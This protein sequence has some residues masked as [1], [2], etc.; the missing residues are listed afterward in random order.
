MADKN[1]A[2]QNPKDLKILTKLL[3]F[4][5][6]PSEEKENEIKTDVADKNVALQKPKDLKIL[7]KLLTLF[8]RYF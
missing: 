1:A 6:D 2:L 4:F 8:K 5:K 7:T 3:I